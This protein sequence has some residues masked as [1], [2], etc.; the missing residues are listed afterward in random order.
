LI[1]PRRLIVQSCRGD[2]LNGPRG[3]DNVYEQLDVVRAAYRLFDAEDSL[4]HD[5]REGEHC[6]HPEVLSLLG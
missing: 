1:A 3:L 2:H 5:I 6:F 4:S